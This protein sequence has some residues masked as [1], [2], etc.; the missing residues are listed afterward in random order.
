LALGQF[1]TT[2]TDGCQKAC[3][4]YKKARCWSFAHITH[5]THCRERHHLHDQGTRAALNNKALQADDVKDKLLSTRFQ[6]TGGYS[7]FSIVKIGGTDDAVRIRVPADNQM[8]H[9]DDTRKG[10]NVVST[11]YQQPDSDYNHF[12]VVDRRDGTCN[13]K[14]KKSGR[15]M[16]VKSDTQIVYTQTNKDD[17]A[18]I[19]TLE[20]AQT[21]ST[22]TGEWFAVISPG[23]NP[24]YGT[25]ATSG[26]VD[27]PCRSDEDCSLNGKCNAGACACRPAWKGQRCEALNVHPA[28]KGTG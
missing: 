8:L 12:S 20:K 17:P 18:A 21:N 28:T 3:V 24:S 19:S 25:S 16:Y 5:H 14:N 2:T 10:T 26:V 11:K 1:A 27:W 7:K 23:F 15:C 6:T 9:T 22:A 4:G 13:I